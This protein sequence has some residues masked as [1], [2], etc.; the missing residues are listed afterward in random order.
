MR[1]IIVEDEMK[2]QVHL[3]RL[4]AKHCPELA[5]CGI[6]TSLTDAFSLVIRFAPDLIFLDIEL[7][8]ENGFTLLQRIRERNIECGAIFTTAHEKYGIRAIKFSALDYLLKPIKSDE[9]IEAVQKAINVQL[10]SGKNQ[11]MDHL[12]ELLQLK[13]GQEQSIAIPLSRELRFVQLSNILQVSA[14]NNY[15]ILHLDDKENLT[16]SKGIYHFDK[17]LVPAGFIRVHQ[18][19]IVNPRFIR[20][21]KKRD[22][23]HELQ[24][25]NGDIVPV[26]RLK[27]EQVKTVLLKKRE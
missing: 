12:L 27:V 23:S 10:R 20:A 6:A 21:I 15:S 13:A 18:S 17:L 9:L 4:L 19:H 1:A 5:I 3:S 16:V 24:L 8:K 14:S 2:S 11:Q 25:N 22:N 7:G 26:S